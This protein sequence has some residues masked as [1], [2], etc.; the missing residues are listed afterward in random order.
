MAKMLDFSKAKKP[1]M[2]VKFDDGSVIHV[3]TPAK[4]EIEEMLDA[5]EYFTGALD[6][7]RECIHKLYEIT[8]RLMSNNKMARVITVDELAAYI[9]VSDIVVFFRGYSD[10]I[11][12]QSNAK[13]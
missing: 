4:G 13:N 8:A 1:T 9:D 3:Y 5:Q 7:E 2:P 6:G 11:A 10:F 12:E